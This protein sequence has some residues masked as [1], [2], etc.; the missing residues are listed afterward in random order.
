MLKPQLINFLPYQ[1]FI[2]I[3]SI[4]LYIVWFCFYSSYNFK[5]V[6]IVFCIIIFIILNPILKIIIVTLKWHRIFSI[7]HFLI[8]LLSFAVFFVVAL[9][10]EQK[11]SIFFNLFLKNKIEEQLR[12]TQ[13][14]LLKKVCNKSHFYLT[15]ILKLAKLF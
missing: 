5:T 8:F 1:F 14:T 4:Y 12:K 2:I 9:L 15:K 3:I 11:G 13:N 7:L 6:N 10:V